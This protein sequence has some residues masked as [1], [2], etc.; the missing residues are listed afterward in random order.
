LIAVESLRAYRQSKPKPLQLI[1]K[2]Q[3]LSAPR[4]FFGR[5]GVLRF[6]R[7]ADDVTFSAG[8]SEKK[9]LNKNEKEIDKR[10]ED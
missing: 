7:C 10:D 1:E 8:L 2:F 6:L 4:L 5:Y 9:K 3:E